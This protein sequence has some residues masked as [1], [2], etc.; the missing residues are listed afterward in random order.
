ML[1]LFRTKIVV[2][3]E[4]VNEMSQRLRDVNS[5]QQRYFHKMC[6]HWSALRFCQATKWMRQ[7][8]DRDCISYRYNGANFMARLLWVRPFMKDT[9]S[10]TTSA[11]PATK[12][13]KQTTIHEW[14]WG[15]WR[16]ASKA[17]KRITWNKN[18]RKKNTKRE[19]VWKAG[20][21]LHFNG[22]V[23]RFACSFC[24][25]KEIT[26]NKANHANEWMR[27]NGIT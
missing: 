2:I 27:K 24:N 16:F 22:N 5:R 11:T 23:A 4:I 15:T 25:I 14:K 7:G 6:S 18:R 12:K 26:F 9:M 3:F 19:I 13:N 8:V 10:M 21:K 1:L 17:A 20:S